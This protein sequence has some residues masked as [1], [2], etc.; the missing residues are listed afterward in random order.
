MFDAVTLIKKNKELDVQLVLSGPKEA[1][2]EL[3]ADAIYLGFI[4]KEQIPL[5]L[6]ACDVVAVTN[7]D[8][9]FGH[10]SYPS[11]LYEAMACQVH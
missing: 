8:S 2:L 10:Y 1:G 5:L 11:K 3:P 7:K 6:N 4:P 9:T